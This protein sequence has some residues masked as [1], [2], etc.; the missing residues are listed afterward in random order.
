[1][2]HTY[3]SHI[4]IEGIFLYITLYFIYVCCFSIEE[5]LHFIESELTDSFTNLIEISVKRLIDPLLKN[6]VK[7]IE[8]QTASSRVCDRILIYH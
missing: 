6:W 3:S 1:M 5:F 8:K 4:V 2:E 7:S